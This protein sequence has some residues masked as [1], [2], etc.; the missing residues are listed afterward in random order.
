MK[1]PNFIPGLPG[2]QLID[3]DGSVRIAPTHHA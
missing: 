3:L 1:S 2:A